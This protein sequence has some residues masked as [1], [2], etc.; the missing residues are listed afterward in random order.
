MGDTA[1]KY[2]PPARRPGPDQQ[3]QVLGSDCMRSVT[4]RCQLPL[5][6]RRRGTPAPWEP[7]S[8]MCRSWSAG[9][10]ASLWCSSGS[11]RSSS[12]SAQSS[13]AWI[14]SQTPCAISLCMR[15]LD[16]RGK[17][18]ETQNQKGAPAERLHAAG[19]APALA[20]WRGQAEPKGTQSRALQ[21]QSSPC[22]QSF[23]GIHEITPLTSLFLMQNEMS[24]DISAHPRTT[25]LLDQGLHRITPAAQTH[26]CAYKRKPKEVTASSAAGQHVHLCLDV[27]WPLRNF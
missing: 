5:P 16:Q 26:H 18:K 14:F 20:G 11:S 6:A 4:P 25:C 27:R 3:Q 10:A 13:S 2:I 1:G 19:S 24:L 12:S 7:A 17:Q 15:F 23:L 22:C 9:C 8:H 21:G